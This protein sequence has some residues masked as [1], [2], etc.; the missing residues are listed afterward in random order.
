MRLLFK[1]QRHCD[2][3]LRSADGKCI[4]AVK[5]V[6]C[7][8]SVIF[9]AMFETDMREINTGVVDIS[10]VD[11]ETLNL[12][13]HFLYTDTLD[14]IHDHKIAV[15]LYIT[16]DKYQ[17]FPLKDLCS[18]HL[19]SVASAKNV[20]D[21]MYLSSKYQDENLK[22]AARKLVSNDVLN[23]YRWENFVLD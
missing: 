12:L 16:A 18:N 5:A 8:R 17:I 14:N 7:A 13:L 10:D 20:F 1:S 19:S 15:K 6:L 11:N 4:K 21:I 23:S 3:T 9:N 2:I 22:N